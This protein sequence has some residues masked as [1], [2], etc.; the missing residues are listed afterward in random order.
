M[1]PKQQKPSTPWSLI[2]IFF[3]LAAIVIS[4]GILYYAIQKRR[5]LTDSLKE[6]S[7][8]GDL[9]IKQ[10][11]EWRR[12]RIAD[13]SFLTQNK[14]MSRQFLQY[15]NQ[16]GDKKLEKD[17]ISDLISLTENYD[18]KNALFL[19]DRSNV[20]LFYPDRDTVIGDLSL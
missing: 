4:G 12:E 1:N 19:D 3:I 17:L 20:L 16:P 6:L 14:S 9:K 13:G 15:L 5:V 8:I 10:I 11:T 2:V 7:T 18:Y